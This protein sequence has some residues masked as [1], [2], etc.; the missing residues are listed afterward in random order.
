M[1]STMGEDAFLAFVNLQLL[2]YT[3]AADRLMVAAEPGRRVVRR[4]VSGLSITAVGAPDVGP[5]M[6]NLRI[7]RELRPLVETAEGARW[8]VAVTGGGNI[9]LTSPRGLVVFCG[10]SPSGWRAGRNLRHDLSRLVWLADVTVEPSPRWW[11]TPRPLRQMRSND[12]NKIC[13][14]IIDCAAAPP[15]PEDRSA[16]THAPTLNV[17]W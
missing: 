17:Y 1:W 16:N 7:A 6:R 8:T 13:P 14:S 12:I 4:G 15:A 2:R 11:S 9:R 5:I 10:A 3:A